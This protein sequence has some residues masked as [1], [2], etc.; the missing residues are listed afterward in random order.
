[1]PQSKTK[2]P[3]RSLFSLCA[4]LI[5]SLSIHSAFI[6]F[7]GNAPGTQLRNSLKL[8][9]SLNAPQKSV[10]R[11]QQVSHEPKRNTPDNPKKNMG[12]EASV[13]STQ[14]S[15]NPKNQPEEI[16]LA[17]ELDIQP[18]PAAP[19]ILDPEGLISDQVRGR[20]VVSLLISKEGSITWIFAESSDF[21]EITNQQLMEQLRETKFKSGVIDG[22][23]V[24]AI[25]QIEIERSEPPISTE[26][27]GQRE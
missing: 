11:T 26:I 14:K 2:G 20:M 22:K 23:A 7:A 17:R 24:S 15:A 10:F 19:L 3:K 16:F 4:A 18:E 9:V 12:Q 1:M 6:L 5:F 21:D 13:N 25:I 8:S 27:P